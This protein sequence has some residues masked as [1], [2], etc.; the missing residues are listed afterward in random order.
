MTMLG[1]KTLPAEAPAALSVPSWAQPAIQPEEGATPSLQ[2]LIGDEWR[3]ATSGETF[4]V[5]S[6]IDGS[7]IA[8]AQRGGEDDVEAAVAA[9]RAARSEFRSLPTARRLEICKRAAELVG[10]RLDDFIDAIVVDLGKTG[11]EARSEATAT[12]ERL[13]LV[14]EEVRKIFGEYRAGDWVPDTAGKNAVLLREP[15]GT[16]AAIGGVN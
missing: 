1:S 5:L 12:R 16:V 10:E 15:R 6:P 7:V 14:R 11:E 3:E 13:E 2:I 9:A 8:R 4:D